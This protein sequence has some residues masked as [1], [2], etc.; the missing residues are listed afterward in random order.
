M[1][2]NITFTYAEN[3][4]LTQN[5][6]DAL[7]SLEYSETKIISNAT[8]N[9]NGDIIIFDTEQNSNGIVLNG[10]NSYAN[11]E[12]TT[13]TEFPL[14]YS[15]T[16]KTNETSGVLFGDYTTKS[17]LGF[18]EK[19]V[20]INLSPPGT[21]NRTKEYLLSEV[22][23][24]TEW[25]TF[26]VV[27]LSNTEQKLYLNGVEITKTTATGNYWVWGDSLSYIGTRPISAQYSTAY[28]FK[29]TVKRFMVYDKE[30]TQEEIIH[31]YNASS[32]NIIT[33]Q[34]AIYYDFELKD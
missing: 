11:F 33:D 34:L 28:N 12:N 10:T 31:N 20:V 4:D 17:A 29:G 26:D 5:F 24:T 19:R 8:G 21:E 9:S 2:V 18:I 14:T 6:L 32:S 22:L 30:L 13:A 25:N 15:I 27:Y 1:T 23:S 16:F 3:A 7:L